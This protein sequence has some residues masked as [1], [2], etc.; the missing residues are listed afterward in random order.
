M[1][2]QNPEPPSKNKF[3]IEKIITLFS[4]P[5]AQLEKERRAIEAK[6]TALDRQ[7]TLALHRDAHENAVAASRVEH[8]RLKE[9]LHKFIVD[10]TPEK[11]ARGF[12]NNGGKI[13]NSGGQVEEF[14]VK[15]NVA[16]NI[17]TDLL[18]IIHEM[19]KLV[20]T[21]KEK[22]R[23]IFF[24]DFKK[25]LSQ[26]PKAERKTELPF[27]PTKLPEDYF[28]SGAAAAEARKRQL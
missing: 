22:A 27:A 2:K 23:D 9:V 18:Q 15:Y 13:E 16:K 26:L 1:F 14:A 25:E 21:P 19:E 4:G 8:Q 5:E 28:T 7:R 11:F 12:I 3:M 6:Q 20:V 24:R 17:K 10:C